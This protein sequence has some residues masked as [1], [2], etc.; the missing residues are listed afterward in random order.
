MDIPDDI[1]RDLPGDLQPRAREAHAA[2]AMRLHDERPVPAAG[3]R[4]RL[5]SQLM[6]SSR[7]RGELARAGS[8]GRAATMRAL[9]AAYAAAGAALLVVAAVGVAGAGPFAA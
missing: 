6:T 9:A 2:A 3:F 4:S 8:V 1:R 5:R 7:R